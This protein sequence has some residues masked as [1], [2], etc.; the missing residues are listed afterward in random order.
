MGKKRSH[1]RTW[2]WGWKTRRSF[3][4]SS[5]S[6]T[7]SW[8]LRN[9][10]PV[11]GVD[12]SGGEWHFRF[13]V[14]IVEWLFQ[15]STTR[16]ILPITSF[17][18]QRRICGAVHCEGGDEV[19]PALLLWGRDRTSQAQVWSGGWVSLWWPHFGSWKC[20][21]QPHRSGGIWLTWS[22]AARFRGSGTSSLPTMSARWAERSILSLEDLW[23]ASISKDSSRHPSFSF[24]DMHF[25]FVN[26]ID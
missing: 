12:S 26:Y 9:P 14:N 19:C 10:T 16:V 17:Q 4:S 7:R 13:C 3:T 1:R 5:I 15:Y 21:D 23:K 25:N 24:L 22:S 20:F 11:I 8:S 18:D 2:W 6:V